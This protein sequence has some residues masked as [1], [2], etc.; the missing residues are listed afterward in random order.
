MFTAEFLALLTVATSLT[1]T[2]TQSLK[3]ALS[4]KKGWAW[5]MSAIVAAVVSLIQQLQQGWNVGPFIILWVAVVLQAN[6]VYLFA[7]QMF[8]KAKR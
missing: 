5:L 6:G 2:I 3:R 8:E 1:V 7:E 4:L